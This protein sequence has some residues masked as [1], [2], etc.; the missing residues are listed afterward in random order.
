VHIRQQLREQQN[1]HRRQRKCTSSSSVHITKGATI[2]IITDAEVRALFQSACTARDRLIVVLLLASGA[3]IAALLGIRMSAVVPLWR[4]GDA[5]FGP[6][7]WDD[8]TEVVNTTEKGG[9][10]HRIVLVP[11]VRRLVF[12]YITTERALLK[13]GSENP[14]LFCAATKPSQPVLGTQV[15]VWLRR[16]A[17]VAGIERRIHCHLFRH[18]ACQT[19]ADKGVPTEALAVY[20]AH[21]SPQITERVGRDRYAII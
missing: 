14:Y 10:A 17:T 4:A 5:D 9:Q 7:T 1:K 6:R 11:R 13:H 18:T 3:R 15:N 8:I 16:L 20:M 12:T 19:L 21:A 2:E